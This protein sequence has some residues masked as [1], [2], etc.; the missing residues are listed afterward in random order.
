MHFAPL[1]SPLAIDKFEL[2]TRTLDQGLATQ[3]NVIPN[4]IG[5][6][7]VTAHGLLALATLDR[8]F[9]QDGSNH[10]GGRRRLLIDLELRTCRAL[11]IRARAGSHAKH[12][13]LEARLAVDA[14][15]H[16][17]QRVVRNSP[18]NTTYHRQAGR[19]F[20]GHPRLGEAGAREDNGVAVLGRESCLLIG[21]DVFL[22]DALAEGR[23]SG[24]QVWRNRPLGNISASGWLMGRRQQRQRRHFSMVGC[25]SEKEKKTKMRK[26]SKS[27][28]I[29]TFTLGSATL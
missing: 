28:I 4:E 14:T 8:Q 10:P 1:A 6:L 5:R 15:T 27:F 16:A 23:E 22:V 26:N 21:H 2:Q 12:V 13:A 3:P 25:A 19:H 11:E 17:V 20:H 24:H 29:E 18:T 9:L 7:G